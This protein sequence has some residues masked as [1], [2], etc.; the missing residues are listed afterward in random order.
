MTE[1]TTIDWIAQQEASRQRAMA[2]GEKPGLAR[3]EQLVGMGD[4]RFSKP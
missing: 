1:T 3:M 4:E 2:A